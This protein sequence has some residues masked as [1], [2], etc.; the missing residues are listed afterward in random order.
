MAIVFKLEVLRLKGEFLKDDNG[1]IW[2]IHASK[3][4]LRPINLPQL[5]DEIIVEETALVPEDF[6]DNF[7][8]EMEKTMTQDFTQSKRASTIQNV[9]DTHYET[10][11]AKAG[12]NDMLKGEPPY[13]DSNNA[14]AKLRPTSPYTLS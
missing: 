11:K 14:F 9:L 4:S 8:S 6:A 2:L 5:D 1:R 12:I 13:I 10:I 3:I 7:A